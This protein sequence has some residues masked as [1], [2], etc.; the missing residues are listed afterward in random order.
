MRRVVS[1]ILLVTL[2]LSFASY[3]TLKVGSQ[4]LSWRYKAPA[5]VYSVAV[6]ADGNYAVAGTKDNNIL[7]FDKEL[8]GGKELW[9]ST[10]VRSVVTTAISNNG[11]NSVFGSDD[12]VIY[13][14]DREFTGNKALWQY[15]VKGPAKSVSISGDGNYIAAGSYDKRV[16]L[17]DRRFMNKVPLWYYITGD[18]VSSVA[19]SRDGDY[20]AAASRDR[21]VYSFD[22]VYTGQTFRWRFLTEGALLSV[23]ISA[24]GS[25]VVA[26]GM[27]TYF[28]FADQSFSRG[29]YTWR[30]KTGGK[31]NTVAVSADGNYIAAGSDDG[32]V[33]LCDRSFSGNNYLWRFQTGGKVRSVALDYDGSYV[34]AGSEDNYVYL[35]DRKLT[36]R[37]Y[38]WRYLT[39][40]NVGQEEG[41]GPFDADV[42]SV[43]ISDTG[44]Y[45]VAGSEDSHVYFF[46][47]P[48][49][50]EQV[51]TATTPTSTQA[52]TTVVTTVV[53]SKGMCF[54]ASAAYGSE[55]S[56]VVQALRDFRN[57]LVLSTFAG[58]QFM[59]AFNAWY[60]SFSPGVAGYVASSPALRM[61]VK[62]LIYP[63]IGI[64][65][66]SSQAYYAL[67]FNRELG[68]TMSG[69][70]A[71]SL[72]GV[73]YCTP[74]LTGLLVYA[75]KRRGFTL[76][77][78]SLGLFAFAWVAAILLIGASEIIH[79]EILMILSTSAFVLLT[80]G[81]AAVTFAVLVTRVLARVGR[82]SVHVDE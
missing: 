42:Y 9:K 7:F 8:T 50:G 5:E 38:L 44:E 21:Y 43:S 40:Q 54:I 77:L 6:S 56:P 76:S 30:V 15:M 79:A 20:I 46:A 14:F 25:S 37:T 22:S 16:Y 59:K 34:I 39:G 60:Y 33:Y 11:G 55:L 66:I 23:A 45:M 13:Y 18:Q 72:I 4:P 68:V 17:F 80:L 32:F 52:M 27:D 47:A 63:L 73:T 51:T 1:V 67:I 36:A 75:K 53:T 58:T 49:T 74:W 31:V 57:G 2:A 26:G 48:T 70:L 64:L 12:A 69:L 3:F 41:G 28:Y 35:F 65:Q 62:A 24:D 71:S 29:T 61:L 19:I 10:A 78:R 81:I 82:H